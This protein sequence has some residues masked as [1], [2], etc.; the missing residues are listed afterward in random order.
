MNFTILLG[1]MAMYVCCCEG[2]VLLRL[3]DG[4]HKFEGR[5]EAFV[6]GEWGPISARGWTKK[7]AQ[8]VCRQ[9]G[10]SGEVIRYTKG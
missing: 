9:L 1:F 3:A 6:D 5:V 10:F 2:Q 7:A 4:K 8:V